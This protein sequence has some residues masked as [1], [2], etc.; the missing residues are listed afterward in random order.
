MMAAAMGGGGPGPQ[1]RNPIMAVAIPYGIWFLGPIVFGILG[2]FIPFI[3][4]LGGLCGL[5][6]YIL[7]SLNLHKMLKEL[8]S[9]TGDTEIAPWMM[10]IAGGIFAFLKVHPLMERTRQQRGL[11]TP[12]KPNWLYLVL[13]PFAF[14]SDL[15]DLA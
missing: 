1:K 2:S 9:I 8:K 4:S 10:W 3:G 6:G 14:A 13:A 7:Y 12:A 15:N 11:P 5:A